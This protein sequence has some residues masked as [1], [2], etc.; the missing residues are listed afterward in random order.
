MGPRCPAST[1]YRSP[2]G[3]KDRWRGLLRPDAIT[4]GSDWAEAAG[5]VATV[6]GN[7]QATAV[8]ALTTR[9]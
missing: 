2:F 9:D 3:E 6:N 7:V 1:T 8:E 5:A 4:T